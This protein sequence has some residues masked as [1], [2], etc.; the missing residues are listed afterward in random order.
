MVVKETFLEKEGISIKIWEKALYVP[1]VARVCKST[2]DLNEIVKE[3]N[4]KYKNGVELFDFFERAFLHGENPYLW[5]LSPFGLV[6]KKGISYNNK[7]KGQGMYSLRHIIEDLIDKGKN[8]ESIK[9]FIKEQLK[10]TNLIPIKEF[11]KYEIE[12]NLVYSISDGKLKPQ[13]VYIQEEPED[14]GFYI[15]WEGCSRAATHQLVRHQSMDFQQQSQRYVNYEKQQGQLTGFYVPNEKVGNLIELNTYIKNQLASL[16]NYK[17]AIEEGNN[18]EIARFYLTNAFTSRIM[19]FI[20][21]ERIA[22]RDGIKEFVEK[23][24]NE[25]A[26]EEIRNFALTLKKIIG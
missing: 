13:I 1:V 22:G 7:F 8:P 23:R 15:C 11:E 21:K 2:K 14:L 3:V 24:G 10:N 12:N 6:W 17:K 4:E 9:A 18:P 19:M 26:Q 16:Y 25:H 5:H 20:P